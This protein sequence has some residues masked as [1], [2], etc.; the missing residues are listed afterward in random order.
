MAPVQTDSLQAE[1][2]VDLFSLGGQ[3][4]LVFCGCMLVSLHSDLCPLELFGYLSLCFS[5]YHRFIFGY[6]H[7]ATQVSCPVTLC[8][9]NVAVVSDLKDI[10]VV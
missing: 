4:V 5:V 3:R 2:L 10:R 8:C 9:G 7:L 1:G 6:N